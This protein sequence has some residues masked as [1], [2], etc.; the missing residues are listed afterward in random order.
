MKTEDKTYIGKER[1][2]IIEHPNVTWGMVLHAIREKF[3]VEEYD[4]KLFITKKE[5]LTDR[6]DVEE[7]GK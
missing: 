6:E 2:F 7:E 1:E 3:K 5:P 4:G